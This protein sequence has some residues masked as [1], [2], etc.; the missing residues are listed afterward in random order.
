MGGY[1]FGGPFKGILFYLG[2]KRG[3][4]IL[5]NTH[6][7]NLPMRLRV[8]LGYTGYRVQGLGLRVVSGYEG[9]GRLATEMPLVVLRQ[10][11]CNG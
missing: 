7:L 3:T 9:L 6:M 1:L 10:P 2:Y 8:G 5:G 11:G 4:P